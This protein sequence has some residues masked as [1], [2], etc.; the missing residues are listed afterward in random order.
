[1]D[2][3]AQLPSTIA[4]SIFAIGGM[5]WG[6]HKPWDVT[7]ERDVKKSALVLP[8]G[9]G[10][11]LPADKFSDAIK[12]AI[13]LNPKNGLVTSDGKQVERNV[14]YKRS[15]I[16][17]MTYSWSE[18]Q[19]KKIGRPLKLDFIISTESKKNPMVNE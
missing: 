10:L 6:D 2:D 1:M 9:E 15:D 19:Q 16:E 11:S 8:I 4:D 18:E 12:G 7:A 5:Q 3:I 17:G 14:F 13:F